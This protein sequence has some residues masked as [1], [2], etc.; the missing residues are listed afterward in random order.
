MSE[1]IVS[2]PTTP[3]YRENYERIF[4]EEETMPAVH[5]GEKKSE[6]ISR[7]IR[8]MIKHEGLTSDQAKG[9]AYGMWEQHVK[10]KPRKKK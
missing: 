3:A 10:K 2:R 8:Y 5:K 9:K 7:A 6:Y 4:A 1:R